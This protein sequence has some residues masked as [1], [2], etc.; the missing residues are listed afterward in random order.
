ML[1]HRS[2]TTNYHLKPEKNRL[3]RAFT[4]IELLIV[5]LII[6]LLAGL[7]MAVFSRDRAKARQVECL[8]NLRQLGS[9][10]LFYAQDFDEHLPLYINRRVIPPRPCASGEPAP[11]LL[12]SS[13]HALCEVTGDAD[14]LSLVLLSVN[15]RCAHFRDTIP[16][17]SC[18][19]PQRGR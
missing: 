13:L 9:A 4:L 2:L 8:S 10:S 11:D 1:H 16:P 18:Q 6:A 3:K 17:V 19:L 14:H 5:I 7:L 12:Y 15:T